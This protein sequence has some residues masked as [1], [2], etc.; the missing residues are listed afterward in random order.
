LPPPLPPPPPLPL[1]PPP[2]PPLL[3]PSLPPS[4]L[5]TSHGK[6]N[7]TSI[8]KSMILIYYLKLFLVP[9]ENTFCLFLSSKM[10]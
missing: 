4:E 2:L 9:F 6:T 8:H 7:K 10:L 3:P 5:L 1:P